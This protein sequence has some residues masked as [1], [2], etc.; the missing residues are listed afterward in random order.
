MLQGEPHPGRSNEP[1]LTFLVVVDGTPIASFFSSEAA[2]L[3]AQCVKRDDLS[4]AVVIL[5]ERAVPRL[6]PPE[7][8]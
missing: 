1:A 8:A 5:V 4:R 7:P 6:V 3:L 2:A